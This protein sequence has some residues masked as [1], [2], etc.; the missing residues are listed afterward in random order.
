MGPET[1]SI[2]LAALAAAL[3]AGLAT[4]RARA[5]RRAASDAGEIASLAAR[6]E[7]TEAARRAAEGRAAELATELA[8]AGRA[9]RIRVGELE[10]VRDSLSSALAAL[11]VPVWRRSAGLRIVDCNPAF[12]AAVEASVAECLDPGRFRARA[13]RRGKL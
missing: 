12:A 6:L 2:L 7:A 4:T 10:A 5:A 13:M 11:S 3:G 1:V 9:G 8:E